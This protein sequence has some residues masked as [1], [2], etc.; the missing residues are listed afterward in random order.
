MEYNE[1]DYLM[2][3]GIQH[4]R[5]CRRHWALIHIEQQWSDNVHTVIGELMH[6]RVH[7]P[8]LTEK[9]KDIIIARGL[10]V[11]SR[12]MGVSGE[13][14]VVE[15]HRCD[16]GIRLHGH[17]GLFSVYPIE[18]KKGRPKLTEEDK[19]QLAA[20]AMC[21]EEMFSTE[22]PEGA[23][24]YGESRRREIVDITSDLRTEVEKMFEEMHQYYNR[25]Y[26]PKV[27]Y[28]KSCNAC[29]LKDICLP[30]LGKAVSV[31]RYLEQMLEEQEK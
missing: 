16:D 23:I 21:L 12:V 22:V 29:S 24:F 11:S 6:K 5:F 18:Y 20:Q 26:T 27:K 7:D 4:F 13:C 31:K 17:R 10:P 28:S 9:R 2:I 30:K 15:F 25:H 3:S 1:D 19:L 14:D 8:Y